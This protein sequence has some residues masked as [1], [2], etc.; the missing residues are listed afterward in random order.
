MGGPC[1]LTWRE[2]GEHEWLWVDGRLGGCGVPGDAVGLS[3]VFVAAIRG[4]GEAVPDFARGAA[5][6]RG[7]D[8]A[9]ESAAQGGIALTV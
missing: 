8:R 3:A 2:A 9:E 6:Q 5:L 4:R 1:N 7:P